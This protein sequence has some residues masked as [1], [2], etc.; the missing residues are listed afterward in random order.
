[1][2]PVY[3]KNKKKSTN[4]HYSAVQSGHLLSHTSEQF[5]GGGVFEMCQQFPVIP[6]E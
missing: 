3:A 6:A 2:I 1:M 5:K 4:I